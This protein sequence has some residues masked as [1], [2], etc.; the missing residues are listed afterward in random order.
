MSVKSVKVWMG[1][2]VLFLAQGCQKL[3]EPASGTF[4]YVYQKTLSTACIECHVPSGAATQ[5]YGVQL[6]FTLQATAYQTLTSSM[7]SGQSSVG[8]CSSV[9]IVA[10]GSPQT[11][12]LA[13]VL[14][15]DYFTTN[16]AGVAGCTPYSAHLNDQNLSDAEKASIISWIQN[17][18]PN[19]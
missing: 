8:A 1:V 14:F 18:A 4:S 19:N 3:D 5:L 17:G 2:V 10:S 12:F 9:R 6:D 15:T 7:V 11:S 13:G 16:F